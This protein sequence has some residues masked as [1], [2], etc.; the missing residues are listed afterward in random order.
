MRKLGMRKLGRGKL[1]RGKLG[2][3]KLG[4]GKLGSLGQLQLITDPPM[5]ATSY[6]EEEQPIETEEGVRLPV[7]VEGVPAEMFA[8]TWDSMPR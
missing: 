7:S 8:P 3:R 6:R 1:G 2:K 5:S 4:K